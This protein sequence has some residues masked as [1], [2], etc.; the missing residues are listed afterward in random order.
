MQIQTVGQRSVKRVLR[1]PQVMFPTIIFPLIL[2][3]VNSSGL[4]GAV[5]LKGFPTDN[6]LNFAIGVPFM[7]S[8]LFATVAAGGAIA[9]D[10][11]RGF[12]NR[13][14]LTPMRSWALVFGQLSGAVTIGLIAAIAYL[15]V[16]LISGVSIEAGALGALVLIVLSIYN[17]LA[18]AAVGALMAL[19]TGSSEAVQSLFPIM[20]ITLFLSSLSLPRDLIEVEWFRTIA[21]WNPV[22]YM[23]EGLRSPIITGWDGA[24]IG[25]GLVAATGIL[26]LALWGCSRAL[27]MRLVRT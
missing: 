19:R 13:L 18:F 25:K 27:R 21:T 4:G 5:H 22:S 15:V 17:C 6:Y 2:L 20:F 9:D 8:A 11:E 16:G 24:A 7:Q 12:L 26:L 14:A 10:I 23:I 3:A 1:Q